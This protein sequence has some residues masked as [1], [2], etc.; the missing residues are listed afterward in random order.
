MRDHHVER[1]HD[2]DQIEIKGKSGL[3]P[4]WRFA[5]L[6]RFVVHPR[7]SKAHISVST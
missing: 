6:F 5:L 3:D 1:S 4:M 7:L 2:P